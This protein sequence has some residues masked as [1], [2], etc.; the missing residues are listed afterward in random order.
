MKN[1]YS[2]SINSKSQN[3]ESCHRCKEKISGDNIS[4]TGYKNK[5]C[6]VRLHLTCSGL[7]EHTLRVLYLTNHSY[8]CETCLINKTNKEDYTGADDQIK[9]TF[10]LEKNK[11]PTSNTSLETNN[12][13]REFVHV[14][15]QRREEDDINNSQIISTSVLETTDYMSAQEEEKEDTQVKI[16]VEAVNKQQHSTPSNPNK[17]D[18][19]TTSAIKEN[20]TSEGTFIEDNELKY[21]TTENTDKDE[22][23]IDEERE[24]YRKN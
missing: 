19:V 1:F 9:Q 14:N 22:T 6:Y 11:N 10:E 20:E 12:T 4:C 23:K 2:K 24:K 7:N 5:S 15:E 3:G 17:H 13:S 18:K 21:S 16:T 8:I